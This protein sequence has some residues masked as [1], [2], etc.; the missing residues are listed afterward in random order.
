MFLNICSVNNNFYFY[1][2]S[3]NKGNSSIL[4]SFQV[5]YIA[6]YDILISIVSNYFFHTYFNSVKLS[7]VM[8]IFLNDFILQKQKLS[9]FKV[10]TPI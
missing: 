8:R 9:Y 6:N 3:H 2:K 1:Y 5:Q 7:R 4:F 10:A